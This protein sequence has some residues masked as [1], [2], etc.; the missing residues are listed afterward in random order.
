M[1]VR[2]R[3]VMVRFSLGILLV[4]EATSPWLLGELGLLLGDFLGELL[5]ALGIDG[6]RGGV[7]VFVDMAKLLAVGDNLLIINLF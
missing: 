5:E 2:S 3:G 7:G 4:A 6:C 1:I